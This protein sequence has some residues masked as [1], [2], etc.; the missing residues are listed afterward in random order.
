HTVLSV[1]VVDAPDIVQWAKAGELLLTSGYAMIEHLDQGAEWIAA[2]AQKGCA[3][4]AV[5]LGRFFENIPDDMI[6]A[7]NTYDFP[8]FQLPLTVSLAEHMQSLFNH[9]Q[10]AGTPEWLDATQ[11]EPAPLWDL[12]SRDTSLAE[13]TAQLQRVLMAPVQL[14]SPMRILAHWLPDMAHLPENAPPSSGLRVVGQIASWGWL[15][16]TEQAAS[17]LPFQQIARLFGRQL[18]QEAQRYQTL[19]AAALNGSD[20][21]EETDLYTFFA[22]QLPDFYA[23]ATFPAVSSEQNAPALLDRFLTTCWRLQ[24]EGLHSI[25]GE[26]ILSFVPPGKAVAETAVD[27]PGIYRQMQQDAGPC[28]MARSRL[29]TV[30]DGWM[31]AA[32]EALALAHKGREAALSSGFYAVHPVPWLENFADHWDKE[33]RAAFLTQTLGPLLGAEPYA[34]E[35]YWTLRTYLENDGNL[36][37][38]A[39]Q[40]FIHRNTLIYRLDRLARLLHKD[41]R[42]LDVLLEL[43]LAVWLHE[44]NLSAPPLFKRGPDVQKRP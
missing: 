29:F 18:D 36:S 37:H 39:Q 7:C 13:W 19:I 28:L 25:Q 8:L 16:G 14:A 17:A 44:R 6:V 31:A 27:G 42:Q 33:Q 41:M 12:L 1:N 38:T 24:P 32:K 40:L 9:I 22:Q 3:G 11:N 2:L 5:K 21:G 10:T 4:L 34:K 43:R 35:L 26:G 15:E 30:Q 23:L 20:R